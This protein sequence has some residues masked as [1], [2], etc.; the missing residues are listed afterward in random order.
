MKWF[1]V[2]A[3]LAVLSACAA[4]SSEVR[5]DTDMEYT[6]TATVLED[7]SHGPSLCHSVLTALP[8]RCGTLPI[9]NWDWGAVEGEERMG[10]TIWGE[11]RVVGT[12]DGHAFT[13]T[14]PPSARQEHS[15]A[16]APGTPCAEPA[17]GWTAADPARASEEDELAALRYAGAQPQFAGAWLHHPEGPTGVVVLNVAFTDNLAGHEKE[18]RRLWGGPLCMVRHE[19]TLRDLERIKDEISHDEELTRQWRVLKVD[20]DEV[21]NVVNLEVVLSEEEAQDALDARHGEG[22]VVLTSW[23]RPAE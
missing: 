23:L 12:Y 21:Q 6:V 17:G 7:G 9:A 19:R 2:L 22:V 4:P 13:L 5:E 3:L 11:Y 15:V 18:L 14:R 1:G 16:T 10:G 8:P 20:A